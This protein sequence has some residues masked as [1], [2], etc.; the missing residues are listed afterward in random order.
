[1]YKMTGL[2]TRLAANCVYLKIEH[3]SSSMTEGSDHGL[4]DGVYAI[5]GSCTVY[6]HGLLVMPLVR[7]AIT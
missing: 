5:A 2:L 3:Q 6:T 7:T 4:N 1:M